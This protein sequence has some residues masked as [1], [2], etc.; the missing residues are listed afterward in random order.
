MKKIIYKNNTGEI[1]TTN[2]TI[3]LTA[4]ENE[5]FNILAQNENRF[6][7]RE[8]IY[9]K[10]ERLDY[11]WDRRASASPLGIHICRIRKK[12]KP[13]L[14]IITKTGFGYKLIAIESEVCDEHEELE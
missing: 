14:K 3:Q 11:Y 13:F 2:Q 8:E 10:I 5:I 12:I 9:E 1:I 4:T 6:V 7:N